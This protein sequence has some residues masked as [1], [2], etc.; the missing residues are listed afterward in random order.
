[1]KIIN[2]PDTVVFL[3]RT[4]NEYEKCFLTVRITHKKE[5]IYFM[6]PMEEIEVK[7]L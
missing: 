4:K 7:L 6:D 3:E 2:P 1:M 5:D